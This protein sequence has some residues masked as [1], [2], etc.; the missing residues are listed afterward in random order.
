MRK[1]ILE[2]IPR[3]ALLQKLERQLRDK[4]ARAKRDDIAFTLT[5]EQLLELA[6]SSPHWQKLGCTQGSYQICR[7][8]HSLGYTI[9]NTFIG[10]A[11]DNIRE[12]L[13]RCGNPNPKKHLTP[14][15]GWNVWRAANVEK[16]RARR[17]AWREANPEKERARCKA[18][19]EANPEKTRARQKIW[20]DAHPEKMRRYAQTYRNK[21]AA[22]AKTAAATPIT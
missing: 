6:L 9:E 7:H 20:R 13:Q 3:Q 17:K 16:E 21:K 12:R 22:A 15:A 8:D 18:W 4:R 5:H 11:L 2:Q 19:R 14:Q 10:S 1:E